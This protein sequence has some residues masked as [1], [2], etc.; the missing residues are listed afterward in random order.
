M[1]I[2]ADATIKE[3]LRLMLEKKSGCL[4]VVQGQ[5]LVDIVTETDLLRYV[6]DLPE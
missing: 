5:P 2:S 4:P 1:M 6:A 3:A